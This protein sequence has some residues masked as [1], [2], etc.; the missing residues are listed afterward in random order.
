MSA[1]GIDPGIHGALTHYERG[2]VVDVLDMPTFSM[3]INKKTRDRLDM[4]SLT[5]YFT[6]K[7]MMGVQIVMIEAVGGR[8][9]Q[10][11]SAAF[12]FGYTVGALFALCAQ[13][14]LPVTTVPAAVWKKVL[15]VP[16]KMDKHTKKQDP[17]YAS[18]IITRADELLPEDRHLWRGPNGGLKVDRAESALLAMYGENYQLRV[19]GNIEHPGLAEYRLIY[20]KADVG[21]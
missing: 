11:A 1:I 21:A 19:P 16:G 8:P 10:S 3:V 18:K 9:K 6:L 17:R 7:K 12:V 15:Q 2:R 13:I 20:E 4:V 14:R 5:E